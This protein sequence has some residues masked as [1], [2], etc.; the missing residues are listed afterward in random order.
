MIYGEWLSSTG[1][2][3][4]FEGFH[5]LPVLMAARITKYL[6]KYVRR[7]LCFNIYIYLV[8]ISGIVVQPTILTYPTMVFYF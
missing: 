3:K 4:R 7:R 2:D 1:I 8:F 5:S 6:N